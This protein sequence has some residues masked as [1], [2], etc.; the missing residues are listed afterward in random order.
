[1]REGDAALGGLALVKRRLQA[2]LEGKRAT[3]SMR[4]LN[5]L[6]EMM[7]PEPGIH[8]EE[9]EEVSPGST[10]LRT[11]GSGDLQF[12]CLFSLSWE[13]LK[14]LSVEVAS[15]PAHSNSSPFN[16]GETYYVG[17]SCHNLHRTVHSE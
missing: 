16:P 7:Q 15:H 4:L 9:Q 10:L 17:I 11:S 12:A 6:L 13:L 1:M 2:E 8:I 5:A 3:P 14:Q